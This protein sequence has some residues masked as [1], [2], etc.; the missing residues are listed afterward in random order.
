MVAANVELGQQMMDAWVGMA[1]GKMPQPDAR[2]GDAIAAASLKPARRRVKAKCEEAGEVVVTED[3]RGSPLCRRRGE[4]PSPTRGEVKRCAQS[5]PLW[6]DGSEAAQRGGSLPP[7]SRPRQQ[8]ALRMNPADPLVLFMPSGKR[9]R[10]PLG[11]PYSR[12]HVNLASLSRASAAGGRPAGAAKWKCRK[13]ILPSTRSSRRTTI[14]PSAAQRITLCRS[15][16]N[17]A[18]PPPL[19]FGDH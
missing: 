1:F 4:R 11:T 2:G 18:K 9:G 16:R 15:S 19:L 12:P 5:P 17:S 10:F 14:F 3:G 8:S 7:S 13:A 6:E